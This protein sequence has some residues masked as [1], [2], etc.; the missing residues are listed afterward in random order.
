MTASAPEDKLIAEALRD[1]F[2]W[3]PGMVV[4]RGGGGHGVVLEVATDESVAPGDTLLTISRRSEP[5]L[6][7]S[8]YRC[9]GSTHLP[10]PGAE[11]NWGIW[12]ALV[13]KRSGFNPWPFP[14]DQSIPAMV[15]AI[16][17]ETHPLHEIAIPPS[18]EAWWSAERE[19][20]ESEP[21]DDADEGEEA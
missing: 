16:V 13:W 14:F 6:W 17:C 10:D 9:L 2:G 4:Q 20:M 5:G 3:H 21:S 12:M 7:V 18:V 19:R 1:L 15:L 11:A 8:D